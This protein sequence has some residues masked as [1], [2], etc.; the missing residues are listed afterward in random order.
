[1]WTPRSTASLTAVAQFS[2]IRSSSSSAIRVR[3]PIAKRPIGVEPSKLSSTETSRAPASFSRRID[4]SASTAERANR[5]RRA[6]TIPPVSPRSQRASACWN[7]GR[8]QLG[9]GLV[10]LLPPLTISTSCS[11]AQAAIFLPLHLGRDERL[12]LTAAAATD[13]DV[14]IRCAGALHPANLV[15]R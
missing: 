3:I 14:A 11:F 8:S 10:D 15:P 4:S 2:L 13:T 6:T 9:A 7:I 1:M 5:S 12:A